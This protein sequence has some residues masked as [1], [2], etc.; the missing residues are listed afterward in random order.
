MLTELEYLCKLVN[1]VQFRSVCE[2]I[3]KILILEFDLKESFFRQRIDL[4]NV[5]FGEAQ[6]AGVR[7]KNAAGILVNLLS[8]QGEIKDSQSFLEYF[9]SSTFIST[10]FNHLEN[11]NMAQIL[12]SLTTT[13]LGGKAHK[14]LILEN[15]LNSLEN[16]ENL[17]NSQEAQYHNTLQEPSNKLGKLKLSLIQ[18]IISA[19]QSKNETFCKRLTE[20]GILNAISQLFWTHEWNSFLHCQ[21]FLLCETI[22][23]GPFSDTKKIFLHE[24]GLV[25]KLID[26]FNSNPR[27]KT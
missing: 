6:G 21:F 8:W 14:D 9:Q 5:V 10:V 13:T 2:V 15:L 16:I 1:F 24:T 22:L 12:K 17:L 26:R 7:G 3:E 4:L 27:K 11:E 25:Q 19:L 23:M 20:T 18:I